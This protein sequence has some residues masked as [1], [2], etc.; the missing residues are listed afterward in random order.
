MF[1]LL[2]THDLLWITL[3]TLRFDVAD[4]ELRAGRTPALASALPAD[5]WQ[6]RHTPGSFTFAAHAAFFAGFLP[7]P[8]AP[9]PHERTLALAFEGS[10]TIGPRTL[11][12]DAPNV[13][14][15][16]E[17]AGYRT[18][19]IGGVGF[20]NPK[21]ALGQQLP[22]LFQE[23]HWSDALGV[24]DPDSTQHQVDLAI[25]RLSSLPDRRVL[26]FLNVSALHQPNRMYL[27]GAREDTRASHA[28]AL[29]YVDGQLDRLF[30]AFEMLGRKAFT[31]VCS[32]H[33]TAYGEDG[34]HGHRLAHEVVWKV[35]YGEF[36]LPRGQA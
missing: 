31:I 35:P 22:S 27:K 33:G 20:F 9:G 21:T 19:C 28:A 18:I 17:L 16:F 5:G 26:L 15:G 12:F 25:A 3:D 36:E 13:V 24:T 4:E 29:R 1:G 10:E 11:V 30:A 6:A 23:R 8:I 34:Y 32:D 7:T 2:G 14:R